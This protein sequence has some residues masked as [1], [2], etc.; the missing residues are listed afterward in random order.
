MEFL[1]LNLLLSMNH[2]YVNKAKYF[3]LINFNSLHN[4]QKP[5]VTP[6]FDDSND[7]DNSNPNDVNSFET[8]T[9]SDV[10]GFSD[11]TLNVE[12]ENNLSQNVITKSESGNVLEIAIRKV[13]ADQEEFEQA[14][15]NFINLLTQEAGV[16]V[17]IMCLINFNIL[18]F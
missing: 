8:R 16:I 11:P 3:L 13:T 9:S 12:V 6:R 7:S 18:Y 14:R 1:W 17:R 2:R 4:L 5:E 10:D 15:A